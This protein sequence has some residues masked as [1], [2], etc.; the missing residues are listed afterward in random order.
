MQIVVATGL[1]LDIPRLLHRA[2]IPIDGGA[3]LVVHEIALL[4]G[5]GAG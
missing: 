2:T 4:C 5:L 3:A 1:W